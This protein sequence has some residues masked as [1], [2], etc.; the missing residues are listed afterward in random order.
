MIN[1]LPFPA[2]EKTG[3]PWTEECPLLP[4]TMP[5]GMPWPKVSIVTPSYNQGQFLEETIRSILLQGYPNLEYII[6]DG[7]SKDNSIEVIRKYEPW[8]AYWVSESDKGQP[9]AIMKGWNRST[10][11]ILGYQNSDDVYMQGTIHKVVEALLKHPEAGAVY[12]DVDFVN[13]ADNSI[14]RWHA[15]DFNYRDAVRSGA[16]FHAPAP[17]SLWR[18]STLDA[19]GWIDTS[20]QYCFD[21]D[22]WLRAG[23]ITNLIRIPDLLSSYRLHP[24]SKTVMDSLCFQDEAI[25]ICKKVFAVKPIPRDIKDV[26]HEC[27]TKVCRYAASLALEAKDRGRARKY[28]FEGLTS[29]KLGTM[30]FLQMLSELSSTDI[31]EAF[32]HFFAG[33]FNSVPRLVLR[34]IVLNP[35]HILNKGVWSILFKSLTHS[36]LQPINKPDAES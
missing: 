4:S 17:G 18:R 20:L 21:Y 13:M 3:W 24:A 5:N 9:Y 11:D 35:K 19:I 27:M 2:T 6:M 1:R 28:L 34:S 36:L 33:R 12:G 10:G 30:G 31:N 8:L 23:A 22:L 25:R 29:R 14:K 26:E 7:G 15:E 16:G 32:E